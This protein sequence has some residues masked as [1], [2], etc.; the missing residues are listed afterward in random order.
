M[1]WKNTEIFIIRGNSTRESFLIGYKGIY[2]ILLLVNIVLFCLKKVEKPD[3]LII[4]ADDYFSYFLIFYIFITGLNIF[5]LIQI[6][7]KRISFAVLITERIISACRMLVI[8][9]V[10]L[11]IGWLIIYFSPVLYSLWIPY[12]GLEFP[13]LPLGP[14]SKYILG[15]TFW[16]LIFLI[17]FFSELYYF[18]NFGRFAT[19]LQ[20]D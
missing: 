17:L 1:V 19:G 5:N 20:K 13:K 15:L 16:L 7:R 14:I 2:V 3:E 10:G 4:M 9:L 8:I 12:I 18:R 11:G 6:F